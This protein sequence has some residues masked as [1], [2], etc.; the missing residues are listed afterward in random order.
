M[1]P[2]PNLQLDAYTRK[3]HSRLVLSFFCSRGSHA[4]PGHW[5]GIS[6]SARAGGCISEDRDYRTL[7][8]YLGIGVA[9]EQS[10]IMFMLLLLGKQF[11]IIQMNLY[12]RHSSL[13]TPMCNRLA[14]SKESFQ[15]CHEI[16]IVKPRFVQHYDSSTTIQAPRI[17]APRIQ[18]PRIQAPA[19]QA[20]PDSRT[21]DSR[22]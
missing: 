9:P 1:A 14:L 6:P 12:P 18:A 20:L 21:N 5:L 7:A 22:T 3:V 13:K 2:H 15:K 16:K 10:Y 11:R 19:I 4:V 17:Q 8:W